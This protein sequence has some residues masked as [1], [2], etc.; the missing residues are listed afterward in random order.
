[1][2]QIRDCK[3]TDRDFLVRLVPQDSDPI[4]AFLGISSNDIARGTEKVFGFPAWWVLTFTRWLRAP[5]AR[6]L[7]AEDGGEPVGF[8]S[9]AFQRGHGLIGTLIT[10]PSHRR[11]GIG[12]ALMEAAEAATR[13][14]GDRVAVLEVNQDNEGARSLYQRRGYRLLFV[15]HWFE[16][17]LSDQPARLGAGPWVARPATRGDLRQV[18]SFRRRS[19]PPSLVEILPPSSEDPGGIDRFARSKRGER[20]AWC[21]GPPEAPSG[22]VLAYTSPQGGLSFLSCPYVDSSTS[23]AQ[24]DALLEAALDWLRS[25][26][27]TRTVSALPSYSTR[28]TAAVRR[29]GLVER[30]RSEFL[31]RELA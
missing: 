27:A 30:L 8:V 29:V 25:K 26:K 6:L 13:A 17:S 15:N 21:L 22:L 5:V 31:F 11:K 4:P 9:V 1:M 19:L 3:R 16:G 24:Q 7:V 2:I 14:R 18:R 28:A 20:H 12:S 23:E 10:D